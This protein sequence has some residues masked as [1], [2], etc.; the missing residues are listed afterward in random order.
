MSAKL[1]PG[2]ELTEAWVPPPAGTAMPGS[3]IALSS[4]TKVWHSPLR[5]WT[6]FHFTESVPA[7]SMTRGVG[8]R[9][10]HDPAPRRNGNNPPGRT[11]ERDAPGGDDERQSERGRRYA[12]TTLPGRRARRYEVHALSLVGLRSPAQ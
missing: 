1:P 4:G 12:H 6:A 9:D 10:Q 8:P 11:H 2:T 7:I 5:S 3:A